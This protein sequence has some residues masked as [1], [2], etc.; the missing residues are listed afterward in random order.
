MLIPYQVDVPSETRPVANWLLVAATI[1]VFGLQLM[2]WDT[3]EVF[4]PFF[5]TGWDNPI[6]WVTSLFLHGNIIH[7]AGNM[8]FL[9]VFGNAVCSKVGNLMYLPFYLLA[10]IAGSFAQM[11]F[12]DPSIPSLGASGAINGMVGAY[13]VFFPT[14]DVS[15]MLILY[16]RPWLFTI[17]SYW[18][19]LYFLAWDIFGAFVGEGNVG[20]WAHIGGF[21][22]GFAMAVVLLK[23]KVVKMEDDELSLLQVVGI[24]NRPEQ[25][26]MGPDPTDLYHSEMRRAPIVDAPRPTEVMSEEARAIRRQMAEQSRPPLLVPQAPAMPEQVQQVM[27]VPATDIIR[28]ACACGKSFKAPRAMAGKKGKCPQCGQVVRIPIA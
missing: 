6:G 17:S 13:L 19:I 26:Y 27:A 20:H 15:C 11:L 3:P 24:D 23:S 1:G 16:I 5:C 21:A 18:V 28:F 14:N 7:L 22:F 8:I 12:S 25:R 9:W 4:T 2:Y 10:G